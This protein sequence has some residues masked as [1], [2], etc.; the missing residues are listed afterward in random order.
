[1]KGATGTRGSGLAD[2]AR[3]ECAILLNLDAASGTEKEPKF[4]GERVIVQASNEELQTKRT[5]SASFDSKAETET[6]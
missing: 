2:L 5:G 4:E 3:E 6:R 1:M